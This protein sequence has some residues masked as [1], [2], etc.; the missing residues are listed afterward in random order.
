MQLELTWLAFE[1]HFWCKN[2][3]NTKA[4]GKIWKI[5]LKISI[6]RNKTTNT[7]MKEIKNYS[8]L[9]KSIW[10]CCRYK[11]FNFKQPRNGIWF[12]YQWIKVVSTHLFMKI[13]HFW[14]FYRRKRKF[15]VY[16]QQILWCSCLMCKQN[17]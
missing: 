16:D 14:E 6:W 5:L 15:L 2:S 7:F 4:F 12:L 11:K 13:Y 1:K 3:K 8:C 9:G 17:K 10:S